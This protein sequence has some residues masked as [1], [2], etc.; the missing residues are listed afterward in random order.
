MELIED[1]GTFRNN[2]KSKTE[3]R[4]LFL[5]AG[6]NQTVI[7]RMDAG[8]KA[9][10]CGCLWPKKRKVK[11]GK[12]GSVL[13]QKWAAMKARCCLKSNKSYL[14]YG[15]RGIIVCDA[16]H[17]FLNFKI[18][19]EKNGYKDFL[20][21]ERINNDGNYCPSNCTFITMA[22][23]QRNRQDTKLNT[24]KVKI[25]RWLWDETNL[26][27]RQIGVFYDVSAKY[28]SKVIRNKVWID[29]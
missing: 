29:I 12:S 17:E 9:N 3:K 10:S 1:L 28:V 4:G 7:K 15:G 20:S 16:W 23:Q 18:W 6:C 25:I 22:K 2:T 13:Y 8:L 19:A 26:T 27:Q 14:N 21:I 5:C 11:H 24:T